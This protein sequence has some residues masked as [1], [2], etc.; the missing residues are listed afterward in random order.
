M[1]I[2]RPLSDWIIARE[3]DAGYVTTEGVHIRTAVDKASELRTARIEKV[4][5]G[6]WNKDQNG[7]VKVRV[8]EG[9]VVLFNIQLA[10]PV[11]IGGKPAVV[12]QESAICAV[13]ELDS[14]E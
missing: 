10:N 7:F 3:V 9:D 2:V 1:K 8:E 13:V 4:G 14:N 12:F 6:R 11:L 5:A